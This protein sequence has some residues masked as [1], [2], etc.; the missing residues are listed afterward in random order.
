MVVGLQLGGG[1]LRRFDGEEVVADVLLLAVEAQQTDS[2]DGR[3]WQMNFDRLSG[4]CS[5]C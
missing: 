3:W 2:Q 1:K 4:P 5:R